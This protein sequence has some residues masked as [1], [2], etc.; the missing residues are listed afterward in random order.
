MGLQVTT[1]CVHCPQKQKPSVWLVMCQCWVRRG[2]WCGAVLWPLTADS[3]LAS[4]CPTSAFMHL[5]PQLQ[6]ECESL[7]QN[8]EEGKHLQNSVKQPV[9]TL[10]AGHQGR[11][12]WGPSHKEATMELLRVKDRAIEL[13]RDVSWLPR[14]QLLRE[15]FL[16]KWSR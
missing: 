14:S 10:V 3:K 4:S 15:T 16:L 8:Q 12:S 7:R 13:E 2:V 1:A 5:S 11:E 9:G 6:K